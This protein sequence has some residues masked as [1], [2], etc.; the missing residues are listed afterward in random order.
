ML[1][2][3]LLSD[4]SFELSSEHKQSQLGNLSI[5]HSCAPW[6]TKVNRM[7]PEGKKV[8]L[9]LLLRPTVATKLPLWE[10]RIGTTQ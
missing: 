1:E 5:F 3:L 4:L 9:L 2:A 6:G 8:G 10:K 7:P